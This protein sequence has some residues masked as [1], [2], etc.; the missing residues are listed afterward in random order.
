MYRSINTHMQASTTC[1]GTHT[2][3][4]S[5]NTD[6]TQHFLQQGL[7][8]TVTRETNCTELMDPNCWDGSY[9]DLAV[10]LSSLAENDSSYVNSSTMAWFHDSVWYCR[11]RMTSECEQQLG[12]G[13]CYVQTYNS[14]EGT[15]DMMFMPDGTQRQMGMLRGM[16]LA[17]ILVGGGWLGGWCAERT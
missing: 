14:L 16:G 13:D 11:K 4:V 15:W 8:Y 12:A 5:I 10:W 2:T 7:V 9:T 17:G 3:D 6:T 1:H